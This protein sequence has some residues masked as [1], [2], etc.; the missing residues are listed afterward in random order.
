MAAGAVIAAIGLAIK[1]GS[2]IAAS[3][4]SA[5]A[6]DEEANLRDLQAREVDIKAAR[7]EK[8]LR[9]RGAEFMGEQTARYAASGVASLEGSPLLV[10][11]DTFASIQEEALAIR[12]GAQFRGEQLRRSAK[13]MRDQAGQMRIASLFGMGGNILTGGAQVNALNDPNTDK[14]PGAFSTKFNDYMSQWS[15][16]SSKGGYNNYA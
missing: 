3:N 4:A 2:D 9:K 5:N 15:S 14:D 6:A 10:L 1:V 11:E 13:S 8:L 7:D 16:S 12:H